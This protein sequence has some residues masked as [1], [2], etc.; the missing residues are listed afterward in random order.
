MGDRGPARRNGI[1]C[2]LSRLAGGPYARPAPARESGLLR[3]CREEFAL[4]FLSAPVFQRLCAGAQEQMCDDKTY[5]HLDV[6]CRL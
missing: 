3:V 5:R 1:R 4:G 6:R 2:R